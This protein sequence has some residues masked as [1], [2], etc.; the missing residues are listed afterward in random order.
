MPIQYR[1]IQK[2]HIWDTGSRF[3]W[4]KP[5]MLFL[6]LVL[7]GCG[8]P[9]GQRGITGEFTH[10]M[11]MAEKRLLGT[12]HRPVY[13]PE[14]ILA[15]VHINPA[16]PRRFDNY[17]GD[18]S[19]RFI[20]VL[21]ASCKQD[22]YGYVDNLVG[23]TNK[24]L[25]LDSIVNEVLKYQYPDG[26]FGDPNLVFT[27]KNI[28][29]DHM[30]LL[31]GNGRLLT[32]LLE[33]YN[34]TGNERV[35]QA[36]R[37]L[38][39]F[40][41][42]VYREVTPEVS[43]RLDGRGADGIICFTQYVEPLVMLSKATGDP[44]YAQAAAEVYP[45]LPERTT[46]HTHGYLTTLRGVLLLYEYD[47]D[48]HHFDYVS[49]AYAQLITSRDFT[50]FGSVME[51]FGGSGNR[52]EGCSTADFIRLSLHLYKLTGSVDYLEHAEFAIYNALYYNQFFTGDFGSHV[53]NRYMSSS[54]MMSACWWCCTMAGLR[55]MQI[56]RNDFFV[57]TDQNII[58][59]NLF[60][61]TRYSD[62][63]ITFSML[64]GKKKGDYHTYDIHIEKMAESSRSF[65]IRQPSWA[66]EVV[67][68]VNGRQTGYRLSNGYI[69]IEHKLKAGDHLQIRT[70]YQTKVILE[71]NSA[72]KLSAITQPVFGALYYGPYVMGVDTQMDAVFSS[73]P[74]NNTVYTSSITNNTG[75]E[76]NTGLLTGSSA[77]DAYLTAFYKHGGFPSYDRTVFR[78][79]SEL[80]FLHHPYMM[81][82]TTFTFKND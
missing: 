57:E 67:F 25:F 31:W 47:K 40:F 61:D 60:L 72:I 13:T 10:R 66:D 59:I 19:G 49:K 22:A 1:P 26:R 11:Q 70:K 42:C 45:T 53:V 36:A 50:L 54:G 34:Y 32:G 29:K 23:W 58:Q 30:P 12:E 33:F 4:V 43:R 21:S 15:D 39:D 79:V 28:G 62:D 8:G 75:N 20:E 2:K 77:G 65:S 38:G 5:L 14:F 73:E 16:N 56:I 71:D 82:S 78:P 37:Q 81:I 64:K 6:L 27:E 76:M 80:T 35:L 69:V 41:L 9:S 17:S 51:Y 24:F 46:L 7:V 44:K 52:D 74:N 18:I 63:Q 68:F 55:A 48:K 3:A